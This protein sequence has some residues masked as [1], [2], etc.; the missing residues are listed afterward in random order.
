MK[1]WVHV[2]LSSLGSLLFYLSFNNHSIASAE[3]YSYRQMQ[4]TYSVRSG[5][6]GGGSSYSNYG[7]SSSDFRSYGGGK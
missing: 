1:F 3:F 7:S 5:S 6:V 4:Y 2:V